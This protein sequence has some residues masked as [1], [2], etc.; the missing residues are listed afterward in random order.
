MKK[1]KKK[2]EAL[3]LHAVKIISYIVERVSV[4]FNVPG[5]ELKNLFIKMSEF[6]FPF[7]FLLYLDFF[8]SFLQP[9]LPSYFSS[10]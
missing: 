10:R 1:E 8:V 5:P 2:K 9:Q 4:I 6:F 7:F 3:G